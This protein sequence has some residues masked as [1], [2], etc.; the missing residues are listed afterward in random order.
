M[1]GMQ[2]SAQAGLEADIARRNAAMSVEAYRDYKGVAADERQAFWRKIGNVKGQN[3]AAM[4]AS[5]IDVDFGSAGRLQDD[6]QMIANEEFE[7]LA[8]NQQQ[9]EKSYLID[10]SNFTTEAKAARM[11]GSSAKT[12]SYFG[13]ATSLLGGLTQAAGMK[14]KMGTAG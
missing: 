3:I 10:A 4:A 14:A 5:G 1:Q 2:A 11:R 12:A 7:A 8:K 13:A 6:T 9:K